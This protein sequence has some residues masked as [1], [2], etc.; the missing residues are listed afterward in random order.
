MM[1][2]SLKPLLSLSLAASLAFG[3]A[4]CSPKP[5]P[6]PSPSPTNS[7][8]ST[9]SPSV[10]A[11]PTP[12]ATAPTVDPSALPT[13][14]NTAANELEEAKLAFPD[15]E[16]GDGASKEDIQ[17]AM[18]G[19][20][21]YVNTIYNSGYLANGSWVKNGAT[22][23]EL[24]KL[25]GKDWSEDYRAEIEVLVDTFHNGE[26]EEI[27]NKAAKDIMNHFFYFIP[28][29]GVEVPKDCSENSAGVA[30][31]LVGESLE[32][33]APPS[34]RVNTA[35][36]SIY[37]DVYFDAKMRIIKDGVQGVTPIRYHVQL[38]MKKNPHPDAA[39]LRYTYIVNELGGD[40]NIDEWHEGAK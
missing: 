7:A 21:R 18:L 37:V 24:V 27:K 23:Q 39:N 13:Y 15:V 3:L 28:Y 31:C 12:S 11:S 6:T 29:D 19:A 2:N 1:K 26:N 34:S 25:F 22:S 8:T 40:W 14:S 33:T 20:Y 35:T 32:Y 36:G 30:S 5:E 10:S 17:L 38:E 16:A 9:P 4:A